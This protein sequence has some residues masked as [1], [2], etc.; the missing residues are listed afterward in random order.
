ML[1]IDFYPSKGLGKSL[2]GKHILFPYN[3][4]VI[5]KKKRKEKKPRIPGFCIGA[6][7]QITADPIIWISSMPVWVEQRPLT[8]EKLQTASQL[9][10]EQLLL[11]HLE[12]SLVLGILQ[13]WS[14]RKK[15]R[16]MEI[17]SEFKES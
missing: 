1:Q 11:G 4:N 12:P 2:Q 7:V 8:S 10:E 14:L 16:K 6:T 3:Q 13:S 15:I 5:K 17:T 9:V